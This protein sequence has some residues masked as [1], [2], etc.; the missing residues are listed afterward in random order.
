MPTSHRKIKKQRLIVY[1]RKPESINSF[2]FLRRKSTPLS[3]EKKDI[4]LERPKCKPRRTMTITMPLLRLEKIF[5]HIHHA[6]LASCLVRNSVE[7]SFRLGAEF[8]ESGG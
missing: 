3:E 1:R 7:E 5:S 2:P 6:R 8:F 4:N